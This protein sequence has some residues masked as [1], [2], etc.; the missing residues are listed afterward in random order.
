MS[1]VLDRPPLNETRREWADWFFRVFSILIKL[2][3]PVKTDSTR[4]AAGQAGRVI[5]NSGDGKL[6]ID[7]GT[8]WTLPDGTVT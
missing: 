6:N 5:F 2:Q 1:T 7:N 4:G 3:L 8:N